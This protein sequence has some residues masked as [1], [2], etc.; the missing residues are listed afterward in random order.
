M[1]GYVYMYYHIIVI[2]VCS[3]DRV[4]PRAWCCAIP[5]VIPSVL[6]D[7]SLF[8]N[9]PQ[10]LSYCQ[11]FCVFLP[12]GRRC[13]YMCTLSQPFW[14]HGS[15]SECSRRSTTFVHHFLP[16]SHLFYTGCIWK[17]TAQ[18]HCN[19]WFSALLWVVISVWRI[20]GSS[21]CNV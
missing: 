11:H 7:I 21:F 20:R 18:K 15:C 5:F 9:V 13:F 6:A 12:F 17:Y 4:S 3:P 1:L 16:L 8:K 14:K 2:T 19:L 10:N